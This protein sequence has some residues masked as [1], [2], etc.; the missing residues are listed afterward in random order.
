MWDKP[1]TFA[2][3]HSAESL[4]PMPSSFEDAGW[5]PLTSTF[6]FLLGLSEI[7]PACQDLERPDPCLLLMSHLLFSPLSPLQPHWP[8]CNSSN[9]IGSFQHQSFWT[10]CLLCPECTSPLCYTSSFFLS[11]R[12]QFNCYLLRGAL[13]NHLI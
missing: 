2:A 4:R 1:A 3:V 12:C 5:E 8:L 10:F 11:F 7:Q 13:H 6:S 9:I